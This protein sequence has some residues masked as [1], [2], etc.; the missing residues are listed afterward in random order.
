MVQLNPATGLAEG[1]FGIGTYP[2]DMD[3]TDPVGF[4]AGLD[5][6]IPKKILGHNAAEL[7]GLDPQRT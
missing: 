7:L 1:S 6:A 4:H 5:S 3:E 2:F